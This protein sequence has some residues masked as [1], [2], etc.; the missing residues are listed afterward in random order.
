MLAKFLLGE[1]SVKLPQDSRF[2]YKYIFIQQQKA[3]RAHPHPGRQERGTGP[4]SERE[5]ERARQSHTPGPGTVLDSR[6]I[7]LDH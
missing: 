5:S 1:N 4:L 3:C 6:V 7:D 2:A